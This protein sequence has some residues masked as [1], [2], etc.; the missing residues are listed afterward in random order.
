MEAERCRGSEMMI[1]NNKRKQS[2]MKDWLT[3]AA[4]AT[5]LTLAAI[6]YS[7]AQTFSSDYTFKGGYPTP[8]TIQKAY[9]DA[10]LSRAIEA[11]KFFYPTVSFEATWRGNLAGG[12]VANQVFPLLEGSPAQIV[13]TPNSDTPYSGLPLDLSDGP[14]VVEI[15]PGPI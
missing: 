4:L 1:F 8:E 3:R 14:M 10:D 2:S 11:Y 7:P 15:P 9:D 13:F 12:A 5:A 6:P